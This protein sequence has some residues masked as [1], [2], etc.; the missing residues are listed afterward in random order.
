MLHNGSLDSEDEGGGL[1]TGIIT[2]CT[3]TFVG[4]VYGLYSEPGPQALKPID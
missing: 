4:C 1:V 3:S 2:G